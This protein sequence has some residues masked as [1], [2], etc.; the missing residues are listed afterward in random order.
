MDTPGFSALDL[1]NIDKEKLKET[2]LE[3]QKY[4]CDFKD[5]MH[6]KEDGC[7]IKEMVQEGKIRLTRYENYKKFI[8]M[9]DEERR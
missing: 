8:E 7:Y 6:I 1:N 3:F 9:L 2:F 5:C 4:E